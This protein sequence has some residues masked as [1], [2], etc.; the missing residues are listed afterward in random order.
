ML[1]D[2]AIVTMPPMPT[3]YDGREAVR[4]FLSEFAFARA[5]TGKEFVEGARRVRLLPARASGQIALAAYRWIEDEGAW[6]PYNLQVLRLEGDKIAE[7]DGF[8]MPE[9]VPRFGLP[10]RLTA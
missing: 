7:I 1:T 10:E 6:L 9:L 4:V 8:V 3:W 2:D 5:W